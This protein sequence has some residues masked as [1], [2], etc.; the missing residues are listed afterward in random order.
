MW[1]LRKAGLGL[2]MGMPGPLRAVT[3]IEDSAVAVADPLLVIDP[4]SEFYEPGIAAAAVTV[5]ERCGHC[6]QINA[7]LPLGRAEISQGLLRRARKRVTEA[8]EILYPY[9]ASGRPIVGLEPSEILTLRDAAADLV[10]GEAMRKKA[11]EVA[12]QAVLFEEFISRE[13]ALADRTPF[14]RND[15]PNTLLVH[16][17]CHQKSLVGMQPTLKALSLIP[18]TDV[19]L[20]ASGC[21]GM[22]GA[23]GCEAEHYAFS[24]QIAELILFPAIRRAP[25]S[26]LIVASGASC[27]QQITDGL[28]VRARHPAE[29]LAMA[30]EGSG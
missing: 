24:L 10:A 25:S 23:F 22:A 19:K 9:A 13:E 30:L 21:C 4:F 5:L 26:S 11:R 7:C 3:G 15:L 6:I 14:A 28:G 29:I 27:R 18:G 20:I 12:D 2:L 16:G 1:S 17:H 8:V